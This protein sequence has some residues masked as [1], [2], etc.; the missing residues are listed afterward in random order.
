LASHG[1]DGQHDRAGQ[2]QALQ[3]LTAGHDH[4]PLTA[5]GDVA[6]GLPLAG[7]IVLPV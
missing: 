1:L 4:R 3:A 2:R 6:Q 7:S 5:F